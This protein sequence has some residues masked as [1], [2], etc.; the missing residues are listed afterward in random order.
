MKNID[1]SAARTT[2]R[3]IEHVLVE[4]IIVFSRRQHIHYIH[5]FFINPH[6]LGITGKI[7]GAKRRCN[8]N[9]TAPIPRTQCFREE[10]R[11]AHV[12]PLHSPVRQAGNNRVGHA[13]DNPFCTNLLHHSWKAFGNKINVFCNTAVYSLLILCL[14]NIISYKYS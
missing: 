7:A 9:K 8:R 12:P 3:K 1:D 10:G 14:K 6:F 13:Q 4:I 11:P 2:G 5:Q